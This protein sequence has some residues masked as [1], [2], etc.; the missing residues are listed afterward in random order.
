MRLFINFAS[1]YTFV[2]SQLLLHTNLGINK[3]L[4]LWNAGPKVTAR[5]SWDAKASQ[6][7]TLKGI[8]NARV[9][10]EFRKQ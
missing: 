10:L 9:A 5:E 4:I 6:D 7:V 2:A 3:Y 8:V 1:V